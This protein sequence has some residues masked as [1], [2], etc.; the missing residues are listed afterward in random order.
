[1]QNAPTPG[2]LVRM[3]ATHSPSPAMN[4]VLDRRQILQGGATAGAALP[5]LSLRELSP[6]PQAPLKILILGG[7]G[8][9]GPHMV[10]YAKARGHQLTLFNRGR[11]NAHLFPEIENIKGDRSIPEQVARLKGRKWDV[12]IDNCGYLPADVKL[13]AEQLA[14]QAGQYIFISTVS[15]YDSKAARIAEDAPLGRIEKGDP[16]KFTRREIGRYYGPLKALCEQEARKAFKDAICTNVR[17]GLIVGPRDRSDRFTYWPH[18]IHAGG[19]ILAPGKPEYRTQFVDARDLAGWCIR[20]AEQRTAGTYNCVGFKGSLSYQELFHGCKVVTGADCSFTWVGDDF[21]TGNGIRPYTEMPLWIP[22]G[23]SHFV[24]EAAQAKGMTFRPVGD[25]IRD[26]LAWALE[27]D[28]QGYKWYRTLSREREQAL[29]AG[30]H[31]GAKKIELPA[32]PRP[33]RRR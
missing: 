31:K 2:G 3:R 15:V 18:R 21:L 12:V 8:F 29:L 17:P 25:T 22:G 27:R 1:M 32:R 19:E 5:L 20:L 26:T 30:F 28:K 10:E 4:R 23:R 6:R 24:N 13:C 16:M 7:K 9:I 14:Q 33:P 11:T